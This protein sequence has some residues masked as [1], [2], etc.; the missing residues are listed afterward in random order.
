MF[1]FCNKGNPER[2]EQR[3]YQVCRY[4]Y[5]MFCYI[6]CVT[7]KIRKS[8]DRSVCLLLYCLMC[9]CPGTDYIF[10]VKLQTPK[11]KTLNWNENLKLIKSH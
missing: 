4:M 2:K 9:S 5:L 6:S 1:V 10:D 3:S 8:K 11:L 7:V